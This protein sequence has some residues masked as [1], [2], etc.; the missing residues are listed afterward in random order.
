MGASPIP[1]G[2][3]EAFSSV[4]QL[5]IAPWEALLIRRLDNLAL[6][7]A[8]KAQSGPEQGKVDGNVAANVNDPDAVDQLFKALG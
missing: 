8:A 6:H 2:E 7:I 3:I 1:F 4:M 5:R